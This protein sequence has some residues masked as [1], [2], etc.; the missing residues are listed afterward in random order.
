MFYTIGFSLL[1]TDYTQ[2]PSSQMP[3]AQTMAAIT[4]D[5]YEYVL[6]DF[7]LHTRPNNAHQTTA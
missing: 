6:L 7:I 2:T 3:G 5:V 1:S 4:A